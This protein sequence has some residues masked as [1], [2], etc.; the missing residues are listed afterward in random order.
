MSNS[1]MH[2]AKKGF[3]PVKKYE[4]ML[5]KFKY[6]LNPWVYDKFGLRPIMD[7]LLNLPVGTVIDIKTCKENN[8][9]FTCNLIKS[10]SVVQNVE[11]SIELS[12]VVTKELS[13]SMPQLSLEEF[14]SQWNGDTSWSIAPQLTLEEFES[15]HSNPTLH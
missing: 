10:F 2:Q 14:E 1:N 7:R 3:K 4:I 6:Y 8:N 15:L 11:S 5:G 13:T 9:G 12:Q